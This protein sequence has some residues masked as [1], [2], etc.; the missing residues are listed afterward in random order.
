MAYVISLV[1]ACS[2][3]TADVI[4]PSPAWVTYKPQAVL[5]GHHPVIMELRMDDEWRVTPAVLEEVMKYFKVLL[6]KWS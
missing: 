5:A 3:S 6:V 1:I 2:V 4:L